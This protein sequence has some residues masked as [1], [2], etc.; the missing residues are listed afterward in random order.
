M[1]HIILSALF[2]AQ[3]LAQVIMPPNDGHFFY[4][5]FL[6]NKYL[7]FHSVTVSQP[8]KNNAV[9]Y[10]SVSTSEYYMGLYLDSCTGCSASNYYQ[11]VLGGS[12]QIISQDNTIQQAK[13]YN[14][15][16]IQ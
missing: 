9:F 10:C 11:Y 12:G 4:V 2:A 14:Q 5:D 7:N 6:L 16:D 3:T 8:Q 13:L 15:L 1:K